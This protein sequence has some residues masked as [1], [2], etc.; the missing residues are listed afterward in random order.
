[1]AKRTYLLKASDAEFD[2]WRSGAD[3]CGL[4]LAAFIRLALNGV[5][6]EAPR[7]RP[8]LTP[9]AGGTFEE[10]GGKAA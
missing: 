7:E 3:A 6:R 2:L 1:M 10:R 5:S 8:V 4:S 9:V